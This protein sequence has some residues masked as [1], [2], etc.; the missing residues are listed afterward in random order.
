MK[1]K[2]GIIVLLV[3]FVLGLPFKQ[4]VMAAT[5]STEQISEEGK[6]V[7]L[8]GKIEH[9]KSEDQY[10]IG[11]AVV[12]MGAVFLGLICLYL[13]SKAS[14]RVAFSLR[15]KRVKMSGYTK[16][17]AKDLAAESGEIFAAIA[18]A[19]DEISDE[20]HDDEN[21]VLTM[22]NVARSYS[23]WSS[24]IYTLRDVPVKR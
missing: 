15:K 22:K 8:I 6:A 2:I 4:E 16:E 13:I 5:Q 18:M 24:K 1:Y 17:E 10:G 20:D 23:P 9:L 7:A 14:D 12:S 19:L 3:S 21:M 11:I